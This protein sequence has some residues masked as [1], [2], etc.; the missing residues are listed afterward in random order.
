MD[1]SSRTEKQRKVQGGRKEKTCS[2]MGK[3]ETKEKLPEK[4]T[5]RKCKC[6]WKEAPQ[7]KVHLQVIER[8]GNLAVRIYLK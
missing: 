6:S 3:R 5:V 1:H 8:E 4:V 2:Y 7:S